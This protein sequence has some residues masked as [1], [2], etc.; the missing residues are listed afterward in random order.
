MM[1]L[2]INNLNE[3]FHEFRLKV[4]EISV[5][6]G[7]LQD[8]ASNWKLGKIHLCNIL[9]SSCMKFNSSWSRHYR[10]KASN[11]QTDG[12]TGKVATICLPF[13]KHKKSN[14]FML[15]QVR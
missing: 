7:I 4:K 12:Q 15:L 9:R 11:G 14:E 1:K 5:T 10:K 3:K 2:L 13:G 8:T 6:I